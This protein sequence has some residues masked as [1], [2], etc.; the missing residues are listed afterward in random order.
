MVFKS[1][2]RI[3]MASN[4]EEA[5]EIA[6]NETIDV[7]VIDIL[8]GG[9]SGIELL[10][11]L[12][13]IEPRIAV[14]ILTAY[15]TLETAR[16]ALRLGASDYLNKPFDVPA[17]RAAVEKALRQHRDQLDIDRIRSEIGDMRTALADREKSEEMGRTRSEI[18]A[19]VL[20]DLNGPLT[21]ISTFAE[22]IGR[23]VRD[24]E[25][26]EGTDLEAVRGGV[27]KLSAQ[28]LRCVEISRRYLRFLRV[29]GRAEARRVSASQVMSDLA[30][31]L[32][33]HP[34][35]RSNELAIPVDCC[36]QIPDI[37]GTDLLQILLNLTIN[38]LQSTHEP[39]RAVVA[40]GA[41]AGLRAEESPTFR[42]LDFRTGRS[43]QPFLTFTVAD[44]GPGIPPE[45]FP[46][47]FYTQVTTKAPG[48]GTGLG[49]SIIRRLVEGAS[50]VIEVESPRGKGTRFS[51]HLP[52]FTE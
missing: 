12:K 45:V 35:R 36:E 23:T 10:R 28:V 47:M 7:A 15:E 51:I 25:R 4:G 31:L 16:Q 44:D 18:Y 43:G 52:L 26:I 37:D 46:R 30:E 5:L 29:D 32:S 22:M 40:C 2:H 1:D 13:E 48:K 39:H 20:H 41:F 19:G 21:V 42:T 49:L 38:A 34:D 33:Y 17:L 9:M 24:A 8:M 11:R 50:G 6:R 14:V 3:L 27:G